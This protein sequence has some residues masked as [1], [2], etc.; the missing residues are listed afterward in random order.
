[1]SELENRDH[2]ESKLSMTYPWI[3]QSKMLIPHQFVGSLG[4]TAV[5]TGNT[6]LLTV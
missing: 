4:A 1:M 2:D 5:C 3:T 6:A